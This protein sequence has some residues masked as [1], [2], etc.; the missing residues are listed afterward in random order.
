[1]DVR[2]NMQLNPVGTLAIW[3]TFSILL[4]L[5]LLFSLFRLLTD[6][7]VK[8]V[9]LSFMIA[10]PLSWYM[11]QSW[12]EDYEYKMTLGWEVFVVSGFLSV[13]IALLTVSYQSVRAALANP[14]ESLRSE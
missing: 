3:L 13:F 11:M 5:I 4:F 14:A 12:L 7:F 9:I 1:M 10:V 6:Q 2:E 8:L